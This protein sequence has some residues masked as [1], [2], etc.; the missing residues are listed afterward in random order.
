MVHRQPGANI[1]ATV[2]RV[3]ALLPDAAARRCPPTS[4]CSVA[5]DRTTT[6]RASLADVERTVLIAILLVVAVVAFFLRNGRAILIPSVAVPVS[7][8]GAWG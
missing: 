1:I 5:V 6:I 3:K 7:L 8:L 4:T 2:D